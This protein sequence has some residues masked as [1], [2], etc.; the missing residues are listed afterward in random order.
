MRVYD[1]IST[2][3]FLALGVCTIIGGLRLGFGEWET[4]GT[5]FIAVL[6][7]VLLSFLSLLWLAMAL[8]KKWGIGPAKKFFAGP[9]SYKRLILTVLVLAIYTFLL[10]K[11]GF[12]ISTFFYLLFLFKTVEPQTWKV[13]TTVALIVTILS[14]C[15]FQLW[16]GVQLPEGLI[17]IYSIK[18]WIYS[19]M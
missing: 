12:V 6:A 14:V 13:A 1:I 7:G 2:I 10:N 9:S 16:L 4:P 17:R 18:K 5:G 19:L 3:F 15:C 11:L 8:T